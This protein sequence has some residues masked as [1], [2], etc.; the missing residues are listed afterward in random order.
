M[1]ACR[2]CVCDC[3]PVCVSVIVCMQCVCLRVCVFP[4]QRVCVCVHQNPLYVS[5]SESVCRSLVL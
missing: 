4:Y 2:L 5:V 3:V 1:H